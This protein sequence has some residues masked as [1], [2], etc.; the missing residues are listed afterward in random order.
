MAAAGRP[1]YPELAERAVL[2]TGAA[3]G[4]GRAI[5]TAFA[6]QRSQ[7]FLADLDEEAGEAAAAGLRAAGGRA[8]ALPVDV[9]QPASARAMVEAT[10]AACGRLDVL[11]N[12]AGGYGRPTGVAE[13]DP[14]EW[15]A[16]TALNLDSVF[17]CSRAAIEPMIATRSGRIVNVAS[18]SGRTVVGTNSAAYG[19]AKAGVIQL[20]RFLAAELGPHGITANAIAPGT[21]L[22]ERVA[23]FRSADEVAAIAAR[24]PLG[25]LASPE[26]H[27]AAALFLASDG[28]AF[29]TGVCLDVT[30]GR[31]ML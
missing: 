21:T 13:T 20:T 5:A 16:V 15:E 25:R 30:G 2:V 17:Y 27:A 10:L 8:R 18:Q 29:I 7:V 24:T 31:V 28:A 14:A 22:T 12:C 9:R 3:R 19:V 4:I 6:E 1:T 11:V 23:A 26:D